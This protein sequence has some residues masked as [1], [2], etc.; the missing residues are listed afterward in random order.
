M[1]KHL[2]V[3]LDGSKF[4]L[5]ALDAAAELANA[6]G[7]KLTA[8]TVSPT[9]PTIMAADGYMIEPVSPEEWDKSMAKSAERIRRAAEKRIAAKDLEL[10]FVTVMFDQPYMGI[11]E[12]AK[13]RKC[14]LIVMASHG[15][16]GISA[17]V[18]GSETTK[19]LTHSK[20]PVLVCR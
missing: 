6:T 10:G 18:L 3:P 5:R 17:L 19:V 12:S 13:R 11:I 8:V 1:Y 2:L 14:D 9:Y 15:R 7:A 4:A 20:I 16:R